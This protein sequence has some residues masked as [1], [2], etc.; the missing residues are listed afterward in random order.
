MTH[1]WRWIP[2]ALTFLRI[3]LIA[4]FAAALMAKEYRFALVIFFLASATDAFDGFLARHYNWRTR[5]GAIADPLA[6]KA[7]LITTY[8]M[9]AIT[10]VLPAWLFWLVLGRDLLIVCGGLAFHYGVGRFEMQP[11]LPG[12]LNTLIQIL[13]ALAIIILLADLPMQP[14]VMDVGILLVAA[15]AIFSGAHYIGVWSL[16]AWRAKRQ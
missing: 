15:S 9:L 5:L 14:W 3:L 2:N 1:R 6:D 11:S 7:L 13:V 8:L 12:K 10:G 4:P 16:R